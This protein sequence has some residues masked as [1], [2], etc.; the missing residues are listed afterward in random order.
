MGCLLGK[1]LAAKVAFLS[2]LNRPVSQFLSHGLFTHKP[3]IRWVIGERIPC[4]FNGL[5]NRAAKL[6]Q[7]CAQ[8]KCNMQ[9]FD[10]LSWANCTKWVFSLYFRRFQGSIA[11][12]F[13]A[14]MLH[15]A[16]SAAEFIHEAVEKHACHEAGPAQ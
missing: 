3:A 12:L 14:Y 1:C 5:C 13:G 2:Q 6:P 10:W 7:S 8:C 9:K 4:L 11:F 16:R 15:I